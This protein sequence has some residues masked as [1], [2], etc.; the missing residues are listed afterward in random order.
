MA[1]QRNPGTLN[2]PLP[3]GHARAFC[4][5]CHRAALRA[6]AL[7]RFR[8]RASCVQ[9]SENAACFASS[10]GGGRPAIDSSPCGGETSLVMVCSG[11]MKV[12]AHPSRRE[13]AQRGCAPRRREQEAT[14]AVRC[15]QVNAQFWRIAL[16]VT[17]PVTRVKRFRPTA[18]S[19]DSIFYRQ[20]LQPGQWCDHGGRGH[21]ERDRHHRRVRIRHSPRGRQVRDSGIAD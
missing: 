13:W 11:S 1:R 10:R 20:R 17:N 14:A 21:Q 8:D 4:G 12:T 19:T 3:V 6:G 16:L 9:P 7:A 2:R 5:A 18:F 15:R